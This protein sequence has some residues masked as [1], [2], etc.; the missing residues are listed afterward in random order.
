M[1]NALSDTAGLLQ[2][3]RVMVDF[4]F[5]SAAYIESEAEVDSEFFAVGVMGSWTVVEMAA[6]RGIAASVA[7]TMDRAAEAAGMN[8]GGGGAK[9]E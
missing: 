7:A 1:K 6:L 5:F 2:G 8:D 9:R 4:V 3:Q